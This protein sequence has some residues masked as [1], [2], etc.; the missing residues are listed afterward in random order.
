MQKS[1]RFIFF[2]VLVLTFTFVPH[3]EA[4]KG[5]AYFDFG[6]FALE[7]SDFKGAEKNFK[8]A[9]DLNPD[10][11]LYNRYLGQ[12]YLKLEQ[13][14]KAAKYL[15]KAWGLDPDLSGLQYDIAFL[16]YK[17]KDYAGAAQLFAAIVA[18]DPENVLAQYHGGISHFYL[19]Q[20][21]QA[22]GYFVAASKMS[23]TIKTN[24]YYYAG[25]CSLE[26]GDYDKAIERLEYVKQNT[27]SES[28]RSHA[29]KWLNTIER[30]K[31]KL[32]RYRLFLKTG[33]QYTSNVTLDP[34]AE[35]FVA[36]EE[37]TLAVVYFAGKYD[38]VK[39]PDFVFGAGYNHYQTWHHDL[40]EY[41][42]VGSI[43]SVYGK[44]YAGPFT[45]SLSY[46][47]HYYWLDSDSYLRR[48]QLMPEVTWQATKNLVTRLS[49]S[50]YDN[51]YFQNDTSD[52]YTHEP[53]FSIYYF[54]KILS[55]HLFGRFGYE[56]NSATHPDRYYNRIKLKAGL[57]IKVPWETNLSITGK[58]HDKNYDN[59][60]TQYLVKRTDEKYYA[61]IALARKIY[62]EWLILT[63]EYNYTKN[64]S[65]IS[66]YEYRKNSG[67]LSL[68]LKF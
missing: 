1:L 32:K 68:T 42:L 21:R 55:G 48:H 14:D 13:Y 45:F 37:D 50:Y 11:P 59:V 61:S 66:V 62:Y 56:D 30:K 22:L 8:K 34:V 53:F 38:L 31:K 25:I 24:G 26:L 29:V 7:D 18:E 35:D 12:T 28:L 40:H 19:G 43:G 16:S 39:R 54:F 65:N 3:A 33:Y 4:D 49:Y 15:N 10:N 6:V 23:P 60:N 27:V 17:M 51:D 2:I 41:D 67:T 64:N 63:G 57:S 9:L 20:Y 47:P 46:L 58:Y 36:D 5:R 52:G 44:A